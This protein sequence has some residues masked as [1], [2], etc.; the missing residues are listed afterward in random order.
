[1]SEQH[2]IIKEAIQHDGGLHWLAGYVSWNVGDR[3]V[4]I[5]GAP[6]EL[7]AIADHME[8]KLKGD[9]NL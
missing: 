2:Q 4:T 1:M 6:D 8:S 7:R 9:E 3:R 5:D